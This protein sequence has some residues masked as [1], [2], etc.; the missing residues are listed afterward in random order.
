VKFF[1]IHR[2][3]RCEDIVKYWQVLEAILAPWC[4]SWLLL[5]KTIFLPKC[6]WR[7]VWVLGNLMNNLFS[8]RDLFFVRIWC[9]FFSEHF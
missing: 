1:E 3:Y 5:L 8:S 9:L 2:D 4:R 6:T 7:W